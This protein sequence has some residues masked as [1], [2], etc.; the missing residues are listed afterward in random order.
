[1]TS[2]PGSIDSGTALGG[3]ELTVYQCAMN[4][5]KTWIW[6]QV[7]FEIFNQK[8]AITSFTCWTLKKYVFP[9]EHSPT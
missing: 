8:F 2:T 3:D 5:Y 1:M 7:S 6:D 9:L 4:D